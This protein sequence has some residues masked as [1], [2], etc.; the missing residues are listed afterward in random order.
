[1]AT[2]EGFAGEKGSRGRIHSGGNASIEE[3]YIR[4]QLGGPSL[5]SGKA[6]EFPVMTPINV[7]VVHGGDKKGT[8]G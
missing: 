3:I 6:P 7:V 1:V 5:P 4:S 2:K 8:K